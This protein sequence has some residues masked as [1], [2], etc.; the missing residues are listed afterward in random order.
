M[1]A[2]GLWRRQTRLIAATAFAVLLILGAPFIGSLRAALR[3]A[4]PEHFTAIVA[5]GTGAAVLAAFAFALWRIRERRALRHGA[6]VVAIAIGLASSLALSSGSAEQDAVERFHFIQYGLL[7]VLFYRV[8]KDDGN[9]SVVVLPAAAG[10]LAG[11][12]E[13]WFQWFV[14]VRVGEVKDVFVNL[15]AVVCGLLFAMALDPPAPLRW[16]VPRSAARAMGLAGAAATL[17]FAGFFGSL[18]LGHLVHDGEIGTF[19]SRYT[20]ERLLELSAERAETWRRDP[21]LTWRRLSR[22]DQY[23]TEGLVHVERRNSAWAAADIETAWA[24]NRILEKYFAPV[25]DTPSYVTLTGHRWPSAQRED[26]DRRTAASRTLDYVSDAY[27]YP[28]YKWPRPYFWAVAIALAAACLIP[29]A[30]PRRG[31]AVVAAE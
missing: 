15:V 11:T 5:V 25:L 9:P 29:F 7:A 18:H 27:P 6:I 2:E 26:A 31:R 19:D 1:A 28:L 12:L 8:W 10:L 16:T 17:A 4:F 3:D 23:L 14:P 30:P 24:E 20:A 13:E 22:E 21:P